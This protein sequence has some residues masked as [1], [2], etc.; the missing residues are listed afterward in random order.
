M[1]WNPADVAGSF[2]YGSNWVWYQSNYHWAPFLAALL[3][4]SCTMLLWCTGAWILRTKWGLRGPGIS[5]VVMRIPGAKWVTASPNWTPDCQM[6]VHEVGLPRSAV[7]SKQLA[8]KG[9][10]STAAVKG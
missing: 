8:A 4:S 10:D 6:G 1:S 5:G 9:I 3:C 7:D 2:S